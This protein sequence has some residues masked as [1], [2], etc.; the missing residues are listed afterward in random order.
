VKRLFA[1]QDV[2]VPLRTLQRVFAPYRQ[3]KRAAE[4]ATVR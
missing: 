4:L 2:E 3:E 1:E